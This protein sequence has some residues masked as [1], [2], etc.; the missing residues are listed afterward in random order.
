MGKL[1]KSSKL[2]DAVD[3]LDKIPGFKKVAKIL[4]ERSKKF[5]E[6]ETTKVEEILEAVIESG[7][8][9]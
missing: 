3:K 6:K 5:I 2:S 4:D 7:I 8:A 9:D 1:D